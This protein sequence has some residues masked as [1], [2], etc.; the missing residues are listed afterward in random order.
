MTLYVCR[1]GRT[2][3]NA[4]GLLL[5]RADP[6]LD[7]LGR[8]QAGAIAAAVPSPAMVVSSPL[9]RCRQTADAIAWS[10]STTAS[11]T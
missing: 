10:S 5:G 1:H 9:G 8:V 4:S 3:A 11:S 7:H 6:D 2:E